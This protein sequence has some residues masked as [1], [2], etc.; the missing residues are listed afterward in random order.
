MKKFVFIILLAAATAAQALDMSVVDPAKTHPAQAEAPA[1]AAACTITDDPRL[2]DLGTFLSAI[3]A[4]EK[5][6][7][8]TITATTFMNMNPAII[9]AFRDQFVVIQPDCS[10]VVSI[11][12]ALTSRV[13]VP[14]QVLATRFASSVDDPTATQYLRSSFA[15]TS[16]TTA[17]ALSLAQDAAWEQPVKS[18]VARALNIA[19]VGHPS[20]IE[21]DGALL[22]LDMYSALG[23]RVNEPTTVTKR[24]T[25]MNEIAFETTG[26]SISLQSFSDSRYAE[27]AIPASLALAGITVIDETGA[28]K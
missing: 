16:I 22:M 18:K 20:F 9:S 1:P 21:K 14:F 2:N 19:L 13:L 25:N 24:K 4:G 6:E 10:K 26:A 27:A 11:R 15:P 28:R 5:P 23:G 17:E 8:L 3:D 7:K 12:G